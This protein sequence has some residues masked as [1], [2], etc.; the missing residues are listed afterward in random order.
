MDKKNDF[1]DDNDV[2]IISITSR[3]KIKKY[4]DREAIR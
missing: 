1:H 4:Y 2:I 3:K